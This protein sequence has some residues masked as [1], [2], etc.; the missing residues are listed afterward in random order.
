MGDRQ[1]NT[2]MSVKKVRREIAASVGWD[3]TE[4]VRVERNFKR[5]NGKYIWWL[6]LNGSETPQLLENGENAKLVRGYVRR[7]VA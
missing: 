1:V 7:L 3:K 4:R 5:R 2:C 6:E